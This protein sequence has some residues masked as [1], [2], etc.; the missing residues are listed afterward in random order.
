[1]KRTHE[2]ALKA[3]VAIDGIQGRRDS[4]SVVRKIWSTFKLYR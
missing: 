1:M 2:P 3:K 4:F